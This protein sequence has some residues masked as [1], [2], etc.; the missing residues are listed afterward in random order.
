MKPTSFDE[1]SVQDSASWLSERATVATDRLAGALG[2]VAGST[3]AIRFP[4]LSYLKM[5]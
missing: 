5:T 2:T 1:V 3:T 4:I